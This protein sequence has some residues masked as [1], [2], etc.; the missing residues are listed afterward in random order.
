[1]P[2]TD[3]PDASV[4]SF[5][6]SFLTIFDFIFIFIFCAVYF[7]ICSVKSKFFDCFARSSSE[8]FAALK[9]QGAST[10]QNSNIIQQTGSG[11]N[12]MRVWAAFEVVKVIKMT[13]FGRGNR[14]KIRA[15][16]RPMVR[17]LKTNQSQWQSRFNPSIT[18]PRDGT[19]Q[20]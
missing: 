5:V 17:G 12:K 16:Y 13:I 8:M 11:A 20:L 19:G 7:A 10:T 18:E 4:F 15:M 9:Q 2:P 1:M 6:F 3:V 14:K